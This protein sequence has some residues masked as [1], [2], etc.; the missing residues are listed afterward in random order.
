[1]I[2]PI[3]AIAQSLVATFVL[4]KV[5]LLWMDRMTK[6]TLMKGNISFWLAYS[7]R[8]S[9]HYHHSGKH[10]SFQADMVL[11]E[12][13]VWNLDPNVARRRVWIIL[14]RYETTKPSLHS[15]TLPLTSVLSIEATPLIVP[16]PM[17]KHIE[18]TQWPKKLDRKRKTVSK[19][20]LCLKKLF[21]QHFYHNQI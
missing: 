11:E 13:T 3:T 8:V 4:G 7:F 10:S 18:A 14:A 1:M 12:P 9:V 2:R 16:L 6:T 19:F 17:A 5:S 21:I 15:D 20:T